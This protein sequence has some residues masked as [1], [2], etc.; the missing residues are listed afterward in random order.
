MR[1]GLIYNKSIGYI[2]R[3]C[4][5]VSSCSFVASSERSNQHFK[6][7]L[8]LARTLPFEILYQL[9][10]QYVRRNRY[11]QMNIIFGKMPF[12]DLDIVTSTYLSD[13]FACSCCNL[14][15]QDWLAVF[16]DP[17]QV[18]LNIIDCLTRLAIVFCA[19]SILKFSPKVEGFSPIPQGAIK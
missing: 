1:H 10:D 6:I 12:D 5:K 2:A 17:Y 14:T 3:R 7:H 19:A 9:I 4:N 15:L 13:Q 11:H 16:C 8:H 18:I